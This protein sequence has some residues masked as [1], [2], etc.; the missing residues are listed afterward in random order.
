MPG[1][2]FSLDGYPISKFNCVCIFI[3][4]TWQSSIKDANTLSY[5]YNNQGSPD[6]EGQR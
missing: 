5:S 2:H 4:Q 1:T 3:Q 6:S